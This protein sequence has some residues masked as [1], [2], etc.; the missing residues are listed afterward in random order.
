MKKIIFI[1]VAFIATSAFAQSPEAL[2]KK[3]DKNNLA[4]ADAKKS[5]VA[6]TWVERA[7][8]YFDMATVHTSKLVPN[9]TLEQLSS[10]IGKPQTSES[11]TISGT[12]FI[13]NDYPDFVVYTDPTSGM[14]VS[15][16]AKQGDEL[17]NLNLSFDALIKL[18]ALSEKDFTAKGA[19][20]GE[21]LKNEYTRAGL[22]QY[23]LDNKAQ[24]ADY[25]VGAAKVSEL[26]GKIDTLVLYYAGLAFTESKD[27][28]KGIEVLDKM[29]SL[30]SDQDGNVYM[31]L[32]NCYQGKKDI[33][34]AIK[35]LE[36]GFQKNPNNAS[37]LST[38]IN[39]YLANDIDP[40]KLITIIKKAEELDP[41]N[42]SLFLVEGTV[43]DKL[44]DFAKA[45]VALKTAISMDDKNFYGYYNLGLVYARR[46][47]ALIEK[48]KALDLNDQKNYDILVKE[49]TDAYSLSIVEL[50][51][52]HNIDKTE[53]S[54][55]EMLRQM[56]FQKRDSGEEYVQRHKYFEDLSKK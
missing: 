26:L 50:E 8:I 36:L 37:L 44:G 42:S 35:T 18:K 40:Q 54:T 41:K 27:Y 46:G 23:N 32:A 28:D 3:L 15:W 24:A 21:R 56:Y 16:V 4:I 20:V 10:M 49:A 22:A 33:D 47:D 13:K 6:A 51:K 17:Q 29:L 48:A 5:V 30:G 38:L 55:I 53:K 7:N 52:A 2:Q 34:K 12:E 25:F 11:V 1:L 39:I 19:P 9:V 31:Y 14:I 43:W 45:E